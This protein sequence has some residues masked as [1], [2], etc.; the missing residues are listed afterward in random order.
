MK[1]RRSTG[2]IS[3]RRRRHVRDQTVGEEFLEE[4]VDIVADLTGGDVTVLGR[5][6]GDH[7][8]HGLRDGWQQLPDRRADDTHPEVDFRFRGK[9]Y[10]T[11][12]QPAEDCTRSGS[13]QRFSLNWCHCVTHG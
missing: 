4:S 3:R 9:Q 11:F 6:G 8:F 7:F 1:S 10:A 12:G 13:R 2:S 5:Q